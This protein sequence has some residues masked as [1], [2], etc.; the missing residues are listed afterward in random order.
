[1]N[2]QGVL[3][4]D[5]MKKFLIPEHLL[6]ET[7]ISSWHVHTPGW[8]LGDFVRSTRGFNQPSRHQVYK[9]YL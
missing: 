3:Q 6:G 4:I 9:K 8:G 1:M 5:A 7:K 2:A